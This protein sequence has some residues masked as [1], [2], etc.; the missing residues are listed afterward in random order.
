M[1][2]RSYGTQYQQY[3]EKYKQKITDWV[4]MLGS[5]IDE[6]GVEKNNLTDEELNNMKNYKFFGK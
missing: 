4:S 5:I 3:G 6:I 1:N 2:L